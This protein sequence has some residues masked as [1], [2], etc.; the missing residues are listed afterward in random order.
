[1]DKAFGQYVVI[2]ASGILAPLGLLL[3]SRHLQTIGISRGS[4]LEAGVWDERV[5]LDTQDPAAV[6]HWLAHQ[7]GDVAAVIAYAPALAPPTWPLIAGFAE[8]VVVVATSRWGE[9]GSPAG[10]WASLSAIVVVQ[11]GWALTAN[12][13]RWHTPHEVSAAVADELAQP[14]TPRTVVVGSLRPWSARSP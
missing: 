3:R 6:T 12:G 13:S 5:A 11:L 9:P 1:M 4:R 10:P 2:G 14:P 8:H 7:R